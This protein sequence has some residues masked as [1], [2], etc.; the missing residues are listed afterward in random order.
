MNE[1]EKAMNEAEKEL[2]EAKEIK[3]EARKWLSKRT[4]SS[5][6]E[7]HFEEF[8]KGCI[9]RAQKL[10]KDHGRWESIDFETEPVENFPQVIVMA[11]CL[12]KGD[13]HSVDSFGLKPHFYTDPMSVK[14]EALENSVGSFLA[15]ENKLPFFVGVAFCAKAALVPAGEVRHAQ[16]KE[17]ALSDTGPG[18][19]QVAK[20]EQIRPVYILSIVDALDRYVPRLIRFTQP[21][22]EPDKVDNGCVRSY[23][24]PFPQAVIE[25][26]A[27]YAARSLGGYHP[28]KQE[29]K[30]R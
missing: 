12:N 14:L 15:M 9:S 13:F 28:D 22:F 19:K 16:A 1:F 5:G 6:S 29:F 7:K 24:P 2:N 25:G 4:D 10:L 27:E 21:S 18:L 23:V 8:V 11:W 30:R 17:V 20:K 3:E 26:T